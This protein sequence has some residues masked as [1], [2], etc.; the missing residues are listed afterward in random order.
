MK[1]KTPVGTVVSI[2]LAGVAAYA[3]FSQTYA[4]PGDATPERPVEAPMVAAADEQP[5]DEVEVTVEISDETIREV[6][7][8]VAE[9]VEELAERLGE[10]ETPAV[11]CEDAFCHHCRRVVTWE[12]RDGA[13][14]CTH[15]KHFNQALKKTRT[16]PVGF[17]GGRVAIFKRLGRL[18]CRRR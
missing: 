15:G 2:L 5:V 17:F 14:Y 6:V 16:A 4:E 10:L 12:M 18:L 7:T 13:W 9:Q 1:R 11:E 3:G 8:A